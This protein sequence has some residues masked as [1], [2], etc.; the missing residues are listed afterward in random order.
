MEDAFGDS[1]EGGVP[2]LDD[3]GSISSR[4]K[5]FEITITLFGLIIISTLMTYL[6]PGSLE[7]YYFQV[8]TGPFNISAEGN[9]LG[10]VVILL[11]IVA[12]TELYMKS[13]DRGVIALV[14][15][16]SSVAATYI[17]DFY[18][19]VSSSS[20]M[21]IGGVGT[22]II[23]SGVLLFLILVIIADVLLWAKNHIE[24]GANLVG[25]IVRLCIV[26]AFSIWIL[27]A[28]MNFYLGSYIVDNASVFL[29]ALGSIITVVLT[30]VILVF[31]AWTMPWKRHRY[32]KNTGF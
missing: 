7:V 15:V 19:T 30:F 22:S 13:T 4:N 2:Q 23:G 20:G 14:A 12:V 28:L 5:P 25:I 31:R 16:V 1:G 29:H 27:D 18:L 11:I 24:N 8:L 21:L 10:N 17:V 32:R 6:V 9:I 3:P 26:F